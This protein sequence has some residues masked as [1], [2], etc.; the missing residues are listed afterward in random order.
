[1]PTRKAAQ[2]N[3]T[4]EEPVNV[5][6]DDQK[7]R[8]IE[9]VNAFLRDMSE[10]RVT[11]EDAVEYRADGS[12]K[13]ALPATPKKMTYAEGAAFLAK[14]AEAE[15]E[16]YEFGEN[17]MCRPMDGAYAFSRVMKDLYGMTAIGKAIHG[18]G[19]TQLPELKTVHISPTEDLQVPWGLMEWPPW[20]AQFFLTVRMDKN[21]GYAFRIQGAAK[22]KFERELQSLFRLVHRYL[23]EGSI[24]KNKAL[25]GVG[26]FDGNEYNE[27]SFLDAYAIDRNEIVYNTDVYK[28]LHHGLWGRIKA[29]EKLL[30]IG[31]RFANKV[32]LHGEN[33]TGKTVA[34]LITAQICLE[35]GLT[36]I[37]AQPDEDLAMVLKFAEHV[38]TPAV[39]AVED[40]EKLVDENP[41]KMDKLLE[42]FDGM[43]TKGREVSLL[44]TTNHPEELPPTLLRAGRIDRMIYISDLDAEAL[45]RLIDVKVPAAQREEIDYDR[46]EMAFEGFKPSWIVG[47]LDDAVIASVIRTNEIGQPLTTDDFVLEAEAKRPHLDMHRKSLQKKEK[48]EFTTALEDLIDARVDASLARHTIDLA[49]GEIMV[50]S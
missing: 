22:K 37:Q 10:R 43:R 20:K 23:E 24:Y 18:W 47:I 39:V 45:R 7:T 13:I 32:L 36:F 41:Q 16:M 25:E 15:E 40:A 19:G 2:Q 8:D 1:M 34:A 11:V 48:P 21:Y 49:D 42:L 46:L 14:Q 3:D 29:R 27:P 31:K 5:W 6:S 17:F 26:I 50:N 28:S 30:S 35:N 12:M 38:G 9:E 44:L 33:G 4:N